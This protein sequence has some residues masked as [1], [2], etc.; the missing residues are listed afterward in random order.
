[1]FQF[2]K[3]VLPKEEK[4]F[5]LFE[6]HAAKAE[7]AAATLRAILDGGAEVA[8]HYATLARQEEHS[9]A[10]LPEVFVEFTCLAC[11]DGHLMLLSQAHLKDGIM[12]QGSAPGPADW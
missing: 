12:S 1:M 5:D 9:F 2:I 7:E 4:F 3:A 8:A 6:A 10:K 11:G